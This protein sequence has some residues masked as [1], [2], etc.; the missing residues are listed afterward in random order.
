VHT[1][2]KSDDT[3]W[4]PPGRRKEKKSDRAALGSD[5]FPN[6]YLKYR[7]C[8]TVLSQASEPQVT[9]KISSFVFAAQDHLV[10]LWLHYTFQKVVV[11]KLL[12]EEYHN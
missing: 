2:Y 12:L 1:C 7:F 9:C 6:E 10:L 5:P 11:T 3:T 8:V 4:P